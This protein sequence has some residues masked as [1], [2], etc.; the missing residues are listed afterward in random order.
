MPRGCART[1]AYHPTEYAIACGFDNGCVRI[2]DIA[3]TSLLEEYARCLLLTY[4]QA[5]FDGDRG[6][7]F[8]FFHETRK[9]SC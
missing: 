6:P 9:Q 2:F 8:L 4:E 7:C 1:V 5:H 3:S